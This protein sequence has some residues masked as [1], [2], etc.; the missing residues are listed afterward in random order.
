MRALLVGLSLLVS[1]FAIS[2]AP[3]SAQS[4]SNNTA[5]NQWGTASSG[6]AV[7]G[8]VDS[9]LAHSQGAA[10]AGAVNAAE[11]GLLL[12]TGLGGLSITSIG[13]QTLVSNTIVGSGNSVNL[14][15]SQSSSNT[16]AVSNQGTI[17]ATLNH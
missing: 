14:T 8:S 2:A 15:S 16:G 17:S 1:A 12:G 11:S 4:A 10:Y 13:S 6:I 5:G 7:P 3:A 9:A